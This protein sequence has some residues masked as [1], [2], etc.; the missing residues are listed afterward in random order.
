M[1]LISRL[2]AIAVGA[3]ALLTSC[4]STKNFVYFQD[5]TAG[6]T[7]RIAD[8]DKIK[9]RPGDQVN[10]LVNSRDPELA[11][12]FTKSTSGN[13]GASGYNSQSNLMGYTVNDQG[14]IEFPIL[15][16]LEVNGMTREQIEV[17]IQQELR[18]KNLVKDAVVTVEFR[19]LAVT[20]LGAVSSPGV[21]DLKRDNPTIL[22]VIAQAGNLTP[23]GLRENVKV[24]RKT[25]NEEK[26]YIVDL[27]SAQNT[28]ASP[29]YYMQQGDIVYVEPNKKA[30]RESTA[31]GNTPYTYGF[32]MS[33]ISFALAIGAIV[34]K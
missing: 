19:N 20:V 15:G 2:A 12:L 22:E 23:N 3:M 28:F 11:R 16:P 32:W 8:Q 24:F 25:G 17:F 1:R 13:G 18:S 7:E 33:L 21:Y 31:N 26:T 9:V 10:I 4:G 29:V 6:T 27:T 34:I 5:T 30:A 14:F